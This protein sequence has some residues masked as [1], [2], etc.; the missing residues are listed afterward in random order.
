MYLYKV[1]Q[2]RGNDEN[3]RGERHLTEALELLIVHVDLLRRRVQRVVA[4]STQNIEAIN[5]VK[6]INE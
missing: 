1:A 6:N 5:T 2:L 4:K 3:V